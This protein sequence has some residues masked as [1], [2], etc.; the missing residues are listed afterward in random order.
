VTPCLGHIHM[1]EAWLAVG[2]T[3]GFAAGL[4]DLAGDEGETS[5]RPDATEYRSDD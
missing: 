5:P 3:V 1:L 4:V 2:L